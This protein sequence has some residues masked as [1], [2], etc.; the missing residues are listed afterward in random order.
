MRLSEWE[1]NHLMWDS[2]SEVLTHLLCM[3]RYF[4]ALETV[5]SLGEGIGALVWSAFPRRDFFPW[6]SP[7]QTWNVFDLGKGEWS[8]FRC[9]CLWINPAHGAPVLLVLRQYCDKKPT[10]TPALGSTC[11]V[12]SLHSLFYNLGRRRQGLFCAL[13]AVLGEAQTA[14]AA[15]VK[16][17]VR[18]SLFWAPAGTD[19]LGEEGENPFPALLH[20]LLLLL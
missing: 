18:L 9:C 13:A 7:V 17:A 20:L 3:E 2:H 19:S 10:Q 11:W 15:R 12:L 6:S 5:L 14:R 16:E 1:C 4:A 8:S